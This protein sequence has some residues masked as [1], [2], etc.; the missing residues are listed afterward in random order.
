MV[1][2]G[3]PPPDPMQAAADRVTAQL[4]ALYDALPVTEQ[5]V[6][7]ALLRLA[8]SGASSAAGD[9]TAGYAV[10]FTTVRIPIPGARATI[11]VLVSR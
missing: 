3:P 5:R 9:D 10:G 1:A 7:E 11:P 2:D 6:L 8:L 4:W